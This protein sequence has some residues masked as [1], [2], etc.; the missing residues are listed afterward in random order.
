MKAL[1]IYQPW[2]SLIAVGAK[3]FETRSWHTDYKG[4]IAIHAGKKHSLETLGQMFDDEG[5]VS[6][7][8]ELF[9]NTCGSILGGDR[10]EYGKDFWNALPYGA[11]IA[12]AY[13]ADCL[14]TQD[15]LREI[16]EDETL[17]GDW[18]PGRYAWEIINVALLPEPIP[19]RG[20][21]GLWEW[22]V[23]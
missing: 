16:T 14:P 9:I 5:N 20:Q 19:A 10:D 1:T 3:M 17:F 13:L 6:E 11:I 21:Q 15:L 8:D 12:T 7:R 22:R 18:T 2:A 4:P 23:A